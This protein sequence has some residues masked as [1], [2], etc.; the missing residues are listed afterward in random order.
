MIHFI[1]NQTQIEEYNFK[2]ATIQDLKDYVATKSTLGVDTETT[3][4]DCHNDNVLLLQIGD[5]DN[6]YVIDCTT[7]DLKEFKEILEDKTKVFLYHNAKFDLR[8]LYKKGIFPFEN[9]YDTFL[10]ERV[11][12]CGIDSHL[13]S[14]QACVYRYFKHNMSKEERGLI[15]KLGIYNSKII[16]Y[17]ANDVK[18]LEGIR[19]FQ[20][21]KAEELGI[22]NTIKL[23]NLFVSVLA[24]IEFSGIKLNTE[25]WLVKCE[26]DLKEMQKLEEEL[27]CLVIALNE[28]KFLREGDLFNPEIGCGIL[29]SSSMQ[30][31]PLMEHLGLNVWTIDKK[32]GKE[33]KSVDKKILQSQKDVNPIVSKYIEYQEK[34]KLVSTY[35]KDFLKHINKS[36]GRIH[37]NFTQIMNTGRLS[38]GKENPKELKPG[39]VNMQNIPSGKERTYFVPEKDCDLIVSDYTGQETMV[40][41]H[42]AKDPNYTDYVTNPGKDLH[43]FMARLIF[44]E[45]KNLSDKEI[46]KNHPDKRSFVKPGTFCIPYGGTGYTISQNLGI[47]K[48]LGEK[49]Y[50]EYMKHFSGLNKYFERVMEISINQGYVLINPITGRKW[51]FTNTE[52]YKSTKKRLESY[53]NGK[54]GSEFQGLSAGFWDVYK[55]EKQEDSDKFKEIK[56]ILTQ[57][58]KTRGQMGR[59]GL[60]SPIQGTSA[61][62]SKLAGIRMFRWILN[63]NLINIVKICIPLH[64]EYVLECPKELSEKVSD[65]VQAEME[66]AA[67]YFCDFVNIAAVPKITNKWEH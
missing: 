25:G 47:S 41:C 29:W 12:Y 10:A 5:F 58:F 43:S 32:T 53:S 64:D 14:L 21:K 54:R 11:L 30:V 6:Q 67:K 28:P 13:K 55:K 60:N 50:S 39:E 57:Y 15:H 36:T 59:I 48:E 35:G 34:A 63:N 22:L 37:T 24:Y 7:I 44:E 42:Y 33:K 19:E 1:T 52:L 40:L 2:K 49:V 38:S 20:L 51:F 18:F 65:M 46:K 61:D 17:S 56:L 27:N 3:G 4:F 9:V 31:I 45:L 16:E 62:I 23:E 8:F 26:E 66:G